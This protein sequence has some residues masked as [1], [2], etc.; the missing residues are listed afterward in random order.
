MNRDSAKALAGHGGGPWWEHNQRLN[1]KFRIGPEL[2]YYIYVENMGIQGPN[3]SERQIR[4]QCQRKE[5]GDG[6][7]EPVAAELP[8]GKVG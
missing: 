4:K 7:V 8:G 6:F 5:D 2:H 1:G 3:A